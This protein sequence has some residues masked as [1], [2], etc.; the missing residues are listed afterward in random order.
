MFLGLWF[1]DP[2]GVHFVLM[3]PTL[4]DETEED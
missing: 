2:V 1:H 3:H 4:F